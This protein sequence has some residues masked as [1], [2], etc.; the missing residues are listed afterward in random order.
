M[1]NPKVPVGK[2]E[3]ITT[4]DI[5]STTV[6]IV[7]IVGGVVLSSMG[8]PA[9]VAIIIAALAGGGKG[10]LAG[11]LL[12]FAKKYKSMILLLALA[13]PF[14]SCV[15]HPLLKPDSLRTALDVAAPYIGGECKQIGVYP[16]YDLDYAEAEN[17]KHGFGGIVGG[18]NSYA[19]I[20]C[21]VV[22][23]PSDDPECNSVKCET[24]HKLK[25]V[26]E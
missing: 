17:P 11:S 6:Q 16:G 25:P 15:D 1:A 9:G 7:G 21:Y 3:I 12:S 14:T 24:I 19:S 20:R 4:H 10:S 22:E 5:L 26:T 8:N 23:C 18:C 13:I 2:K